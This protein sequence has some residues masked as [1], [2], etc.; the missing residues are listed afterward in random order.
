MRFNQT[1]WIILQRK[2]AELKGEIITDTS[3]DCLNKL[4]KIQI[5]QTLTTPSHTGTNV[6]ASS[7][8]YIIK[9]VDS[10][11]IYNVSFTIVMCN[12]IKN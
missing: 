4:D 3:K 9:S 5:R 1:F 11:N 2:E 6:F 8:F 7:N 10:Q 12:I